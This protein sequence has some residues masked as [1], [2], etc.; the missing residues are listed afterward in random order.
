M[1]KL[2]REE[3]RPERPAVGPGSRDRRPGRGRRRPIG[4][5][6]IT[7]TSQPSFHVSSEIGGSASTWN[8]V[9]HARRRAHGTVARVEEEQVVGVLDDLRRVPEHEHVDPGE[10]AA[11]GT[12][13]SGT[14]APSGRTRSAPSRTARLGSSTRARESGKACREV[15]RQPERG[16]PEHERAHVRPRPSQPHPEADGH[17]DRPSSLRRTPIVLPAERARGVPRHTRLRASTRGVL[18]STIRRFGRLRACSVEVGHPWGRGAA[19]PW[20][21]A[22]GDTQRTQLSQGNPSTARSSGVSLTTA[23]R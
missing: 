12:C 7:N 17:P 14:R 2:R 19:L 11:A 21:P 20:T 8:S 4:R 18:H 15:T 9:G 1:T 3:D 5:I 16:P 10:P 6:A 23:P 13:P 22:D